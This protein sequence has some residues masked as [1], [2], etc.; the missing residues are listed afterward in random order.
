MWGNESVNGKVR[1]IFRAWLPRGEEIKPC[2]LTYPEEE[3]EQSAKQLDLAKVIFCD[4][5]HKRLELFDR[6]GIYFF[7]YH[8]AYV[9]FL[10]S[11][12]KLLA[13]RSDY[14]VCQTLAGGTQ[15]VFGNVVG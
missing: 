11:L 12:G 9:E 5:E 8:A 14:R 10:D 2:A 6:V 4:R 7:A 13:D 3:P 15:P 1:R